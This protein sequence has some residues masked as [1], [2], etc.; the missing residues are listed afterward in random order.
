MTVFQ[1]VGID[2]KLLNQIYKSWYHS[3]LRKMLYLMMLKNMKFLA[4]KVLKIRRSA[5]F[6]GHQVYFQYRLDELQWRIQ[7]GAQQTRAPSEFL[8]TMTFF[9]SRFASEC[10]KIRL[11]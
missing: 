2:S 1:E 7:A 11:R 6:W 10:F 5:F 3:L 9:N 8:S 4:R